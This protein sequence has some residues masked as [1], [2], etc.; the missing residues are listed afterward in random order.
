MH[1]DDTQA[2][3]LVAAAVAEWLPLPVPALR[4]TKRDDEILA[5]LGYAPSAAA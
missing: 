5:R 1:I 3:A 4:S 2:E